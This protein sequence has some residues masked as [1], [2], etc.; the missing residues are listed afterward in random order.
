MLAT[1]IG[2]ALYAVL[3]AEYTLHEHSLR[4]RVRLVPLR[5]VDLDTGAV[6]GAGES[7]ADA[8]EKLRESVKI[9]RGVRRMLKQV[10]MFP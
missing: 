1:Y 10:W 3:Y 7:R 5:E 4:K 9:P 2:L 8:D 6:W